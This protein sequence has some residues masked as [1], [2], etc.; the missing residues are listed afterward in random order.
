MRRETKEGEVL[1]IVSLGGARNDLY[2][3]PVG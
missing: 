2:T 3:I 1:M